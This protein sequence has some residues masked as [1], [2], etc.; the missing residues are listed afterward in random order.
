MKILQ[1]TPYYKPAYLYGGPIESVSKLCEGLVLDGHEVHV[2]TTTANGESEL[3]VEH[4]KIIDVNG[5]QV[6]YFS[7][8]TKDPTNMSPKLW[9]HLYKHV[10]SYDIVHVQTW[11]NFLAVIATCICH[12]KRARVIVSPRGMLSN[13]IFNSGRSLSKKIIHYTIGKIALAKTYFHATA[14]AEYDECRDVIKGW[15]GFVLPN[16]LTLPNIPIQKQVNSTFSMIFMSRI[17]PKKGLEILFEAISTLDIPIILKIAGSGDEV[18]IEQLKN[19]AAELKITEKIMWIGWLNRDEKFR[20][21]M[22][23]DLFVLVS[24]NENFANVVI[25]SLH[26][27]TP[28]LLS[29]DVGLSSFV[30][31]NNLGWLSTLDVIDVANK[32]IAAYSDEAKRRNINEHGRK[33]IDFHFSAEKLIKEYAAEYQKI[34]SIN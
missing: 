26:M 28:V 2:F 24:L 7:R 27:G 21:L 33:Q 9:K 13:Y 20:E 1:I 8:I 23:S 14:V 16:I 29:N 18:Y 25:E 34:S 30:K 22:A 15:D 10:D 31:Q 12:F 19:L 4:N 6:I 11:W 17:H 32:I 5:V 3:P